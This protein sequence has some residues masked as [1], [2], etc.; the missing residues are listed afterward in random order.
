MLK[1]NRNLATAAMILT[2]IATVT[3][4]RIELLNQE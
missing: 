2:L 4:I 3:F 1:Q